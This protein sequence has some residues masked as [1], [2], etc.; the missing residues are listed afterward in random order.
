MLCSPNKMNFTQRCMNK[1]YTELCEKFKDPRLKKVVEF[2][3]SKSLV[4]LVK[5]GN[6]LLTFKSMF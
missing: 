2:L 3:N 6:K 1:D 5:L 4:E